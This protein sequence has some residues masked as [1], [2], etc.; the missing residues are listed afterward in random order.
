[1]TSVFQTFGLGGRP[2][3]AGLSRYGLCG[4]ITK[5]AMSGMGRSAAYSINGT[6]RD[7]YI[8]VDNGGF[9]K[10]FEPNYIPENGVFGSRRVNR[11]ASAPFIEAKHTNYSSNGSGRDGYISKINGGFYPEQAVAAYRQTYTEQLRHYPRPKT[12]IQYCRPKQ[13]AQS[14]KF[15]KVSL[16]IKEDTYLMS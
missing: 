5:T 11:D 6:G 13:T 9:T 7:T 16:P 12:P 15:A 2:D 14:R 4:S 1:M 3:S 10:P 8:A